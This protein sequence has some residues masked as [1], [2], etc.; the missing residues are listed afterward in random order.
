MDGFAD[1]IERSI[2]MIDRAFQ[3]PL[4]LL[5][6]RQIGQLFDF[7]L[8]ELGRRSRMRLALL[9]QLHP[10]REF[11]PGRPNRSRNGSSKEDQN[12]RQAKNSHQALGATR[13]GQAGRMVA[14][15]TRAQRSLAIPPTAFAYR[16]VILVISSEL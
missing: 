1:Q 11:V 4:R 7:V 5:L 14:G 3:Q 16:L 13:F 2:V 8:G 15:T 6:R 12:Q 9:L 10:E